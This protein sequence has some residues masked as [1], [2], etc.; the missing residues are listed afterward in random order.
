[1]KS[2]YLFSPVFKKIGWILFVIGACFMTLYLCGVI[3]DLL[4]C[5]V[6]SIIPASD[7]FFGKGGFLLRNDGWEDEISIILVSVA[8]LCISFAR[9]KDEDEY[10]S[11]LRLESWIWSILANT[12]L[13]IA[14]TLFVYGFLFMYFAWFYFFSLFLLFICRF[15]YEL[16]KMRRNKDEE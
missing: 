9:E 4:P 1:M 16:Y 14:G 6:F 15:Y 5:T 12:I 2:N 8:L 11:H 13:L 3:H 10:I 7:G